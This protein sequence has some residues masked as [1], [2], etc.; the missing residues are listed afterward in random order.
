MRLAR[1][2]QWAKNIFVFVGPLAALQDAFHDRSTLLTDGLAVL[3]TAVA[4]GLASSGCYVF[5]DLRDAPADRLHPRKHAR[6][7]AAGVIGTHEAV[8]FGLLLLAGSLI[9]AVVAGSAAA[10]PGG[11][12]PARPVT[13]LVL[14]ALYIA[15]VLLYTGIL[16]RLVLVDVM[17]LSSGFVVR[18]LAGCAAAGLSVSTWLLNVAFFLA[19]FLAFGKRLGERRTMGEE[20]AAATRSVQTAYSSNFLRMVMVVSGGVT[21]M[22]FGLYIDH[23]EPEYVAAVFGEGTRVNL[24]WLTFPPAAYC[25]M[26]AMLLVETG[27]YDDPT[28]LAV[29]DR[30]FQFV[31]GVFAV[32]TGVL[33]LL[34]MAEI[35]PATGEGLST[36]GQAGPP[37]A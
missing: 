27:R 3:L 20:G 24:L 7:I 5:N 32:V 2:T 26:R 34:R 29:S 1:P 36:V 6:P 35:L 30:P 15:N 13:L 21:L 10:M 16:K 33:V 19:M 9:M 23:R 37:T 25:L 12:S 18:V 8:R 14:V 17:S 31:A 22:M 28:D 4:L 11:W